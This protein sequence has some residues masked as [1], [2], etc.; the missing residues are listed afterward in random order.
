MKSAICTLFE[1]NYH[2]GVAALINSLAR[3]GFKGSF[4][5][6][7]RGILPEWSHSA[8][9][10]S[11]LGYDGATTLILNADLKV[12]FLPVTV[13][14]HLTNYK[15]V[16][17]LDL[18]A[19][20]CKDMERIAYFDPDIVV[21]CRWEFFET[22]MSHGV[23]LVHEVVNN[24]MPPSHPIRKEWEK[25][26]L[27][28][29]NVVTRQLSSYINAGFF[30]VA[31][32][33]IEFL[34]LFRDIMDVARTHY[35]FDD[36]VFQFTADRSDIFFAKDQ[37]A[38]NIAAM[39]CKCPISEMGPEAMDFVSSGFTMS[40]AIGSPK[41]WSKNFTRFALKGVAPSMA[42]KEYWK[43]VTGPISLHTSSHIKLKLSAL[44]FASFIGRFYRKN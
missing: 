27:L 14:Y 40:H 41:P 42:E 33:Y 5:V 13:T 19:G 8:T 31:K 3:Q 17:M 12:H 4:Y 6:G 18:F 16:F 7:Y 2:F 11:S 30:G 24:D 22:W 10:D 43:N 35:K 37:D 9:A 21:K 36:S 23:A 28:S 15:P 38:L 26:V 39:C 1:G 29:D 25:V 34:E 20:P 32:P 44:K